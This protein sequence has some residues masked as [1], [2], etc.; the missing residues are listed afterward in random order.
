MIV[1]GLRTEGKQVT[2]EGK[3]PMREKIV[4]IFSAVATG[5]N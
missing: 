4:R 3:V 5:M 1:E 2:A